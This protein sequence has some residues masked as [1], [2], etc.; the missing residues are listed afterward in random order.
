[1]RNGERGFV[2]AEALTALAVTAIAAAGLIAALRAASDR[3]EEASIR[4]LALRE[5]RHLLAEASTGDASALPSHGDIASAHLTW[6]RQVTPLA[7]NPRVESVVVQVGWTTRRR[8]GATR[9]ET[10]RFVS[11]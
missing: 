10:Y 3:T 7:A 5:A 8:T 9:L 4:T 6:T 11:P 1:V 2:L